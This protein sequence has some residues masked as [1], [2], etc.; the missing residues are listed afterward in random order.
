MVHFSHCSVTNYVIFKK[1]SR[2]SHFKVPQSPYQ[3]R[4]F[5]F[6]LPHFVASVLQSDTANLS[7]VK[8]GLIFGPNHTCMLA[9]IFKPLAKM[10]PKI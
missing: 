5:L 10:R 1:T 3:I 6:D 9:P 2:R 8:I 4:Q 7:T